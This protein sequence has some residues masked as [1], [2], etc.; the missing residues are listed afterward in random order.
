LCQWEQDKQ[1]AVIG[2]TC[3]RLRALH[4]RN[5]TSWHHLQ[6]FAPEQHLHHLPVARVQAAV[7]HANAARQAGQQLSV[8]AAVLQVLDGLPQLL[9]QQ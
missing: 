4:Q 1:Q 5:G 3:K 9:Q 7:V 6:V 2:P 8:S